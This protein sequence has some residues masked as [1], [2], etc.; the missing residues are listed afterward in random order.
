MLE[1]DL[2]DM[3]VRVVSRWP[4]KRVLKLSHSILVKR[5]PIPLKMEKK[6]FSYNNS[7]DNF[8]CLEP[9]FFLEENWSI[10][11]PPYSAKFHF[12]NST[13]SL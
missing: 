3:G 8:A 4:L 7:L 5:P 12:Y 9:R 1:T 2:Y 10:L 11:T 13:F 6:S